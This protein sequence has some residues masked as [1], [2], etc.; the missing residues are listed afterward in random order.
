MNKQF[1]LDDKIYE[2]MSSPF[3]YASNRL[4]QWSEAKE[5]RNK[6]SPPKEAVQADKIQL[7]IVAE[8]NQQTSLEFC[9]YELD[10]SDLINSIKQA[11]S[12]WDF[13][14]PNIKGL[15][16]NIEGKE[17]DDAQKDLIWLTEEAVKNKD[18]A[19]LYLLYRLVL[20]TK[21]KEQVTNDELSKISTLLN[22]LSQKKSY[23]ELGLIASQIRS[24]I[25]KVKT[26]E[27]I[28]SDYYFA[29]LDKFK[30]ELTKKGYNSYPGNLF[31]KAEQNQ[32]GEQKE[33]KPGLGEADIVMMKATV[34]LIL[35]CA[36]TFLWF[37]AKQ[38]KI[39]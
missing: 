38:Y 32:L 37:I 27:V 28:D 29:S 31:F 25:G 1:N 26:I 23:D 20:G 16:T 15:I 13:C 4:K 35:I 12:H 10:R 9:S 34:I 22:G 39:I 5:A 6:D 21:M 8:Q 3:V 17:F 14:L 36:I 11:P 33:L 30:E 7:P 18:K 24:I 2:I 19:V